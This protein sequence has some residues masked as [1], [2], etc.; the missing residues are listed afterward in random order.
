MTRRPLIAALLWTTGIPGALAA[1]TLGSV[2]ASHHARLDIEEYAVEGNTAL[3]TQEVEA[4][5]YP[6]LGPDV[7]ATMI[8]KARRALEARYHQHGL[9]AV[10][11]VALDQSPDAEG[12]IRL[13]VIEVHIGRV[14]V[15][16]ASF[17]L[18]SE[19]AKE[20]PS[21]REGAQFNTAALS[22]ELATANSLPGREVTVVPKP[23]RHP[24]ELNLDVVVHDQLPLHGSVEVDNANARFST[25][26]R[27]TGSVSYDNL[28]QLGQSLSASYTTAPQNP[29]DSKVFIFDYHIPFVGT[30]YALQINAVE[31][32]STVA[33]LAATNIISNGTDISLRGSAELPGTPGYT[34]SIEAGVDY[35]D[36]RADTSVAGTV[37]TV[38]VTYYP[39]TAS[40]TGI[41][42]GERNLDVLSLSMSRTPPRVGSNRVAID[43]NRIYARGQQL[44]VRTG[45][46]ATETL[47][48]D[49][50]LHGR[51]NTQVSNEP[52]ISNEQMALGGASTVRGYYEVESP[53]DNGY[54]VSVEA[55]SP[56]FPDLVASLLDTRDA[57]QEFRVLGFFDQGGG[58]N[59]APLPGISYRSVLAS[60]GLAA[61]ARLF[62]HVN[63]S[64]TWAM[65]MITDG[66]NPRVT[67]AGTNEILFRMQTEY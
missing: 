45:I 19:V 18:P 44:W 9:Q 28:F 52:L 21:I 61:N 41:I 62:D 17:F 33:S 43:S 26:L 12:V 58:Y 34:H 7:D 6:F 42:R 63:A 8:D 65:P 55:I 40:Y 50:K 15:L 67:I 37:S 2:P 5:V 38:P 22:R 51:L 16:G 25:P 49:F 56:S 23:S 64:L 24:G 13:R 47:P 36:Y 31:S 11:V 30:P 20:M 46:D 32:N 4:A 59:R 3:P 48:W 54:N 27:V 39:L 14:K 53:V 1:P 35:K 29:S 10:Q 57:V 60:T 66:S